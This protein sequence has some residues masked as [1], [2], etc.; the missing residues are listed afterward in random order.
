MFFQGGL[1]LGNT[2]NIKFRPST[3]V[4]YA[5]NAPLSVDLNLSVLFNERIWL[6]ATYRF[7]GNIYS[8]ENNKAVRSIGSGNAIVD[9]TRRNESHGLSFT[10]IISKHNL[11]TSPA[12]Q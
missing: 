6:G 3:L 1:I 10:Q 2:D 9:I 8:I 12:N 4:K 11:L 7:G 5:T